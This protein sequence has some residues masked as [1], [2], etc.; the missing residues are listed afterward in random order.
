MPFDVTYWRI[1]ASIA[2]L[3]SAL[4]AQPGENVAAT[5]STSKIPEHTL[6]L[7]VS[8]TAQPCE[9]AMATTCCV[10]GDVVTLQS[11]AHGS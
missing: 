2:N 11:V 4:F 5:T 6:V 10:Y 1:A 7:M 8:V 9:T 3:G